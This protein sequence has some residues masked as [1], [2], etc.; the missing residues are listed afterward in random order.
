[1]DKCDLGNVV[2]IDIENSRIT[3][4][5]VTTRKFLKDTHLGI[6]RVLYNFTFNGSSRTHDIKVD[7]SSSPKYVLSFVYNNNTNI[8]KNV[9]F[10]IEYFYN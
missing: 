9:T 4:D 6:Y 1:M 2:H 7:I 8:T 5:N 10:D 3:L